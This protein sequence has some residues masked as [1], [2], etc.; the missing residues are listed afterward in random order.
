MFDGIEIPKEENFYPTVI[1]WSDT[2][3]KSLGIPVT[4]QKDSITGDYFDTVNGVDDDVVY[5]KLESEGLPQSVVIHNKDLS[6][7]FELGEYVKVA[8]AG[9]KGANSTITSVKGHVVTVLPDKYTNT[10]NVLAD[11]VEENYEV[12]YYREPPRSNSREVHEITKQ[13]ILEFRFL[14]FQRIM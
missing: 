7:I 8:S 9:K 1:L 6:K 4:R 10:F 11:H 14:R 2:K 12:A 5:L 3:A 13:N